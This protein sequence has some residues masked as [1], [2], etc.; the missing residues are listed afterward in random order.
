M[1]TK[2]YRRGTTAQ[3][4]RKRAKFLPSTVVNF[5]PYYSRSV[6]VPVS[7]SEFFLSTFFYSGNDFF[8]KRRKKKYCSKMQIKICACYRNYRDITSQFP[9]NLSCQTQH[10][11][12]QNK[13]IAQ[14]PLSLILTW[15]GAADERAAIRAAITAARPPTTMPWT[16][17]RARLATPMSTVFST[18]SRC[19]R[20]A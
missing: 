18:V 1:Y 9:Q 19:P 20:L 6:T 14:R 8:F 15:K 12:P 16:W 10:F 2:D 11:I 17:M 13:H 7:R 3:I 4:Q 5:P